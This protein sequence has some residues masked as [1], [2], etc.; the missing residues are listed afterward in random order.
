[1]KAVLYARVSSKEQ[2]K[3]GYSI[4]AQIKHCREYA[5]KKGYQIVSEYIDVESAKRAGRTNFNRMI[6]HI[7]SDKNIQAIICHKV[8]R[9]CRN[10]R[11]YVTVDELNIKPMFV[12][13]EFPDNAAGKLTFGMKV[14]LAKHYIDNLSDETK[15][16]LN[17]KVEQ[18]IWASRA[19]IGYQNNKT[20]HMIDIDPAL[21]P[22][23]TKAFELY[24]TAGISLRELAKR[25]NAEFAH[26]MNGRSKFSKTHLERILKN[27]FYHGWFRWKGH[28]YRG[29]HEPAV[30]K[31]LFD[32]VQSIFEMK[33]KPKTHRHEFAFGGLMTC[34]KCGCAITAEIHKAKYIYYHCTGSKGACDS[35]YIREQQL[36]PQFQQIVEG[37]SIDRETAEWLLTVLKSSHDEE[38]EYHKSETRRLHREYARLQGLIDKAYEDYLSGVTDRAFWQDITAKW[39]NRQTTLQARMDRLNRA[40]RSY[41]ENASRIIELAQSAGR[42]Y[43]KQPAAEKR[44]FLGVLLSNC[45]LDGVML[46]PTYRR[47]FDLIAEGVKTE[48]WGG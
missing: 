7:R 40:N 33:N 12:E 41:L 4:P 20:T 43:V 10:F 16:G 42:L 19:P 31:E 27:P 9:L 23:I 44:K 39:R 21:A 37:I 47:P 5:D 17:E 6:K 34:G 14:L 48:K 29:S 45:I 38:K 11:D 26:V 8:D 2:E 46:Y 13:E 24:S 1:M 28:L 30:T 3:E 35:A 25:L 15:K 32:R 36:E 18:G 22:V